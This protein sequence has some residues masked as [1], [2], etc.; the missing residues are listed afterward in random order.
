MR[1]A[2]FGDIS[3]ETHAVR[4]VSEKRDIGFPLCHFRFESRSV[5]SGNVGRIAHDCIEFTRKYIPPIA[6]KVIPAGR[7]PRAH[8]H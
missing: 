1:L 6:R 4:V 3:I 7:K 8:E 5:G 2:E